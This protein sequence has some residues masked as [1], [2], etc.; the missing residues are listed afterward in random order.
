[1]AFQGS[2]C[3]KRFSERKA[4]RASRE[5]T[6]IRASADHPDGNGLKRHWRRKANLVCRVADGPQPVAGAAPSAVGGVDGNF[7]L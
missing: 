1:V 5:K 7:L 4:S 3:I 2:H 6:R